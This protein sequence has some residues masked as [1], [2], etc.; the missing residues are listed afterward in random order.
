MS[1]RLRQTAL[2][3][4]CI[5]K[6]LK[7]FPGHPG[8]WFDVKNASICTTELCDALK[9]FILTSLKLRWLPT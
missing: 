7:I 4:H 1:E 5:N 8:D 9:S 3:D 6:P 2:A